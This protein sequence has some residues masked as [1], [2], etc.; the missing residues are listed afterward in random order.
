MNLEA[1]FFFFATSGETWYGMERTDERTYVCV[2]VCWFGV[3]ITDLFLR[4]LSSHGHQ[5]FSVHASVC[6]S[7]VSR[8]SRSRNHVTSLG[9]LELGDSAGLD[10]ELDS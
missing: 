3:G 2:Y 1:F 10:S 7:D 8:M 4:S 6:Q 9:D 5:A